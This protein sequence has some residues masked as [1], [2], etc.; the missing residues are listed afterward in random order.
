MKKKL[1]HIILIVLDTVG[2]KHLS[3]YGYERPTSPQLERLAQDCTV[4]SRCLAP[5]CWTVPPHASL[6]T[7]LYPSQHG[8]FEGRF[9]PWD[10]LPHL[11]PMLK[12]SGYAT[13][14]ISTNSLVS[15]AAGLCPG[16]DE[17]HDLGSEDFSRIMG[18]LQGLPP[19]AFPP[20]ETLACRLR[21]VFT[22]KKALRELAGHLW[23][24]GRL[25]EVLQTSW[26]LARTQAAKWL[27]PRPLD[28]TTPFTRKSVRL[29]K[30]IV[31]R[32]ASQ[33]KPF[34]L[35]VNFLQAHQN[36]CPP[37]R[38]RRFSRLSDRAFVSPQ[39]FY[40]HPDSPELAETVATY[41]N[42]YD[43]EILFL[44]LVLGDL[45]DFLTSTPVFPDTLFIITADHGEHFGEK[46]HYTH[47]LSLY[48]ELLWVPLIVRFPRSLAG[49]GPD[50]RL[51]SLN[52]LYATILDA[53]DSPLPRPETSFSLL[54][55]PRREVAVSQ[56]VQ[57]EMWQPY[58]A[59]RQA[60]WKSRCRTFSPPVFAVTTAGGLK[61]IENQDGSMEV[62]DLNRRWLEE[63]DLAPTLPGEVIENYRHFLEDLKAETG[64][65]QATAA[66]PAPAGRQAA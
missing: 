31:Q 37:W 45:W 30:N 56:C 33:E 52:D 2:A 28:N 55:P 20:R 49:P 62:Y 14:G 63:Q 50:R 34:F 46:G 32:R 7:G 11:V 42:L 19:H 53:A 44:D 4:Y 64:F 40:F 18:G 35:F 51:V 15:P 5:A 22:P 39:K 54:A 57:P 29:I 41:A 12:A 66:F 1:P 3:L 58:I 10:N 16:F 65:S 23:D 6:F 38:W 21:Q 8:A 60:A 48:Q 9:V 59:A 47:I 24:T 26:R 13:F 17:F 43:D 25:D 27:K 36:Y 61:I